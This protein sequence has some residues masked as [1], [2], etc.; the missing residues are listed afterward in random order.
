MNKAFESVIWPLWCQVDSVKARALKT[1]VL[2]TLYDGQLFVDTTG[3]LT[4]F[5][6]S[7]Q[8]GSVYRDII[9]AVANKYQS[10]KNSPLHTIRTNQHANQ[11]Y[12]PLHLC[13]SIIVFGSAMS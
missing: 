7:H 11:Y 2:F 3:H 1:F 8:K 9:S 5:T 10:S 6:F 13:H 12:T 4:M